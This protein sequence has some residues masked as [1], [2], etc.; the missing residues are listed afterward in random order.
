MKNLTKKEIE[1][2]RE[3]SRGSTDFEVAQVLNISFETVKTHNKNIFKKLSVRNRSEAI[4][5]WF[6]AF[7]S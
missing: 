1:I 2:L 5:E 6:T 3:L 7:L 4:R